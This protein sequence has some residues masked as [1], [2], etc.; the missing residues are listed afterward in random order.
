VQFFIIDISALPGMKKSCLLS[1]EALQQM[2]WTDFESVIHTNRD[3]WEAVSYTFSKYMT[4]SDT[5]ADAESAVGSPRGN[6]PKGRMENIFTNL[7]CRP[8]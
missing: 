6:A 5:L 7:L 2:L 8:F 3:E 1:K 4:H